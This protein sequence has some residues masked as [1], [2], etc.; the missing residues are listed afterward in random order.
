MHIRALEFH[1]L[2]CMMFVRAPI[3]VK[4]PIWR[5]MIVVWV[6]VITKSICGI[7]R[8]SGRDFA[9]S[10]RTR[11]NDRVHRYGCST[12]VVWVR[13]CWLI[14]G[15]FPKSTAITSKFAHDDTR[16]IVVTRL[17]DIKIAITT[18]MNVNRMKKLYII[19]KLYIPHIEYFSRVESSGYIRIHPNVFEYRAS[20]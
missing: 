4:R 15:Y 2:C 17:L 5:H 18:I 11:W 7:I 14:F 3:L 9:I 13:Q 19:F 10:R 16:A 20:T 1:M 12:H 8:E 6:H